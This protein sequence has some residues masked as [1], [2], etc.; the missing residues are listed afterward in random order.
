[1]ITLCFAAACFA[2]P[3]NTKM[4]TP[5]DIVPEKTTA[6]APEDYR[7]T[8]AQSEDDA[9]PVAHCSDISA[10]TE[11]PENH[12]GV[13]FSKEIDSG[14]HVTAGTKAPTDGKFCHC[15]ACVATFK[16]AGGCERWANQ[17]GDAF[18][19]IP[20]GCEKCAGEAAVEC[21]IEGQGAEHLE[22][23]ES[24]FVHENHD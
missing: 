4:D 10:G 17:D 22:R 12:S 11:V 18:S 8:V 13:F 5:D 19:V 23:G 20:A 6:V 2:L 21:G 3:P 7:P 9:K 16:A 14:V 15:G 24:D 1:M